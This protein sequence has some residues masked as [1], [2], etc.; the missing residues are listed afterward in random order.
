MMTVFILPML[1]R[2][3]D[4]INNVR[5][6]VVGMLTYVIMLPLFIN[7]MQM[8]AM[9]NLHDISWGNRP[10][11]SSSTGTNAFAESAKKQ[12][13]LEKNY[14]MFRVHKLCMWG[15]VNVIYVVVIS[16]VSTASVTTTM[17]DGKIRPLDGFALFLAGIVAYKVFFAIIHLL[18][19]KVRVGCYNDL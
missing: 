17:N 9:S 15:V 12:L 2:P 8:Y 7:I 13:E 1:L 19:F 16:E 10:T 18:Y 4:F 14:K 5:G 11:V 3:M 6:Y